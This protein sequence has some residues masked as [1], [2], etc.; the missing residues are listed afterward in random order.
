M[1][2]KMNMNFQWLAISDVFHLDVLTTVCV[3]TNYDELY[4]NQ[5][6]TFPGLSAFGP[7]VTDEL[8][9]GSKFYLGFG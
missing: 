3:M 9:G 8:Y 2:K 7:L 5:P 1:A 6:I 4:M